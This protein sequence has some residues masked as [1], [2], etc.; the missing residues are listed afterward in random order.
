[1]ET[2]GLAEVV[3]GGLVGVFGGFATYGVVLG[4]VL[5]TVVLTELVTNN[6]AALLMLPVAVSTATAACIPRTSSVE[7]S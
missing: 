1:M 5:A 4:L 7:V 2:S 6:A 3:A